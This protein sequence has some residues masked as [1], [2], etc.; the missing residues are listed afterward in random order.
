VDQGREATGGEPDV[1][2]SPTISPSPTVSF[3]PTISPSVDS[4]S[5]E[6]SPVDDNSKGLFKKKSRRIR[7]EE[8]FERYLR[9][10]RAAPP[11]KMASA[12]CNLRERIVLAFMTANQK[13]NL[14]SRKKALQKRIQWVITKGGVGNVT[15]VTKNEERYFAG[16]QITTGQRENIPPTVP[17]KDYP[18]PTSTFSAGPL[19]PLPPR[20]SSASITQHDQ[21]STTEGSRTEWTE[22]DEALFSK[23]LEEATRLSLQMADVK[24]VDS[25]SASTSAQS[26]H[27]ADVSTAAG[28]EYSTSQVAPDYRRQLLEAAAIW[29]NQ[30]DDEI[31]VDPKGKGTQLGV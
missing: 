26:E 4:A 11:E 23:Q 27:N 21:R 13:D 16:G 1:A 15:Q 6:E 14:K 10:L 31:T 19:S 20:R 9:S 30:A 28:T 25:P 18:S 29:T 24:I 22:E 7:R 8:G 3:S 17:P 2:S 5:V 12:D